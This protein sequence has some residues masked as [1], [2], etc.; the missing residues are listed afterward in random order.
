MQKGLVFGGKCTELSASYDPQWQC[1]KMCQPSSEE[2]QSKSLSHLPRSGTIVSGQL[3]QQKAVEAPIQE[4]DG[5]RLP[6]PT[7]T[8]IQ[9]M[10]RRMRAIEYGKQKKGLYTRHTKNGSARTYTI[11]D[12]LA[13]WEHYNQTPVKTIGASTKLH[14]QYV[15]WMMGFPIGWTD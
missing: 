5:L 7:T 3:Y 4:N 1:W 11:L 2:E 8:Q 10:V 14:H 15:E 9:S 12:A 13:Y 6:T